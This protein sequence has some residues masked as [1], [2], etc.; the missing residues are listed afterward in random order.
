MSVIGSISIKDNVT[1]TLRIIKKEQTSFR[2]DVK[3][4]REEMEKT[5]KEKYQAKLDATPAT[6]ALNSLKS[7]MEPLRKKVVTAMAVK[8]MATTKVKAVESRVKDLGKKVAEPVVKIK[9][10]TGKGISAI[11]GK[12]KE[13]GTKVVIPVAIA[14]AT[15][16]TAV[17]GASVSEG[18]KLEQSRGGVETLFKDDADTVKANANKAFETAGLSANDYMEQ[19]TSFSASLLNSLKGDTAKAATVADQAMVDMADNANKFGTDI[20][21]IQ[22]A[23]QGFAKQNYTMLDNLKLGYGGT[24]SEMERLLKDAGK[25][26]GVKYNLDNL[27]DVYNAIHVIQEKLDVTGTTAREASTTFSGSFGAMKSAVK[28]LLG[29]M[30]SGGD[31]EGAMGSVVETASTFLFKNAVPMVGRV[32]KALPGAV[33]TGIK[34][35]APKIKES[36]GEIVK[37]LKDGIVSALPSSM[38]GAVNQAF[39]GIGNLGSK[40]SA[41]IPELVSFGNSVTNSLSQAAVASAPAIGSIVNTV[42]TMLPVIIPVISSVVSNISSLISQASPVIAGLVSAIGVAVVALAPVFSTIFDG[43]G[44]KVSS[45]IGFIGERMGFIQEVIAVAGPAI[46]SVLTTAW[47]VISPIMDLCISVFELVFSVVQRVFPGIQSILESVWSVVQPIVEGI[48]SAIGKV[49]DWISSTGAK[50]AGSGGSGSGS[51]G[52][53]AAGDNNWRGGLTWVGEE[54]PELVNLPRGSRILPNKESVSLTSNAFGSVVQGS[55]S[56]SSGNGGG[57]SSVIGILTNIDQH[58][59]ALIDRIRESRGGMEVPGSTSSGGAR[60]FLGSITVQIAKLADTI[61]VRSEDDIDEMADKVAKKFV[62]VIVNMG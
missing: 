39:D 40:F 22:N 11:S 23:Y 53:N 50:I 59:S 5:W 35:A 29:F 7:K 20:G 13:L 21:S 8:D 37:S 27:A 6:K 4:T 3:K 45:V 28:N 30:A 62:E 17:V 42:S 54:G 57:M 49:A 14:A 19:V 12:M 24:K 46:G 38:S 58:L 47:S 55:M 9:D 51:V 34:A 36:G 26:S 33:K 41:A 32:V 56:A 48:G 2:E 10:A 16:T 18:A 25:I 60:G 52:K 31:V 15:A 44:E 61:N 43:I 1:A